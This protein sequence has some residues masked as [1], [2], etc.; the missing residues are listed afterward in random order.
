MQQQEN[1]S[2]WGWDTPNTEIVITTTWGKNAI[3]KTNDD[4][5][6][7]TKIRTPK[8]T[9][10]P[11]TLTI[12]GSSLVTFTDVLIG[13]VWFCSGQSNM[14]M[15]LIGFNKSYVFNSE[16]FINAA[17]KTDI[18][19]F[20]NGREA[21]VMPEEGLNGKWEKSSK[22]SVSKF[23]AIGYMF[24]LKLFQ[25][26][27][28][29]IGIIESSWGG[30]QIQ[31]W[32]SREGLL[33]YKDVKIPEVLPS[34]IN[35]QKRPTC[36]YNAMI[37]PFQDFAIK[38][39]LW[40]QGESNRGTPAPYKDYL[41]TLI[42]DWRLQWKDKTLPFY[43]VQIAPYA[44]DKNRNTNTINADLIR[45][46][47]KQVANEVSNTGIVITTDVGNCDDI[48]PPQK[49]TIAE[50]L[51]NLALA[52]QYHLKGFDY[53]SPE[54]K[55]LKIK[56]NKAVLRFK[57]F[58]DKKSN[59]AFDTNQEIKSF[60]VAGKDR[61]FYEAKVVVNKNQTLTVFSPQVNEIIAV[62]YGFEDCLKGSLFSVSGLPVSP[63]RTDSWSK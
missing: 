22:N 33:K 12:R 6:W 14:E 2:I 48:H 47:Q 35:K 36:L 45:E 25:K 60:Y 49:E 29:P 3:T 7:R 32:I 10:N 37:F 41:K 4:G 23:S 16:E 43:L 61:Q 8:A 51:L 34:D 54:Y 50:R 59:K 63:F 17:E 44:Y 55:S 21:S 20:N 31:S 9:F 42:K 15:P 18:R 52:E 39:I 30:T 13:E 26:L 53:K 57:F 58:S 27:K 5:S 24:G 11:Q 40:Y 19:L 62:R 46:A 38:G 1:V 56:E 28:V